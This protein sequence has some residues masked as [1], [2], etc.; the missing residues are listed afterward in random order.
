MGGAA[1]QI[2]RR[3]G[4]RVIGIAR[5]APHPNAP[6]TR[7]AGWIVTPEASE[8]AVSVREL[9]GG[10]GADVVL[11]AV[12]GPTFEPSLGMLA[13][14]GRLSVLSSPSQRRQSF[15]LVD[16]YHNESQLFGVDS[17]QRDMVAS[18]KLLDAIGPGSRTEASSH[19]SSMGSCRWT[20]RP[21]PTAQW[22]EG[23]WD[24]SSLLARRPERAGGGATLARRR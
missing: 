13:G 8:A 12:G 9:T 4:A 3:V 20:A 10:R 2:G 14:R 16:F 22:P 11:N 21:T 18:A 6:A 1:V 17:L 15:D 19:P 5:T 7:I 24:A 23:R